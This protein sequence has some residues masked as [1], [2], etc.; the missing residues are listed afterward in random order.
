M[1]L[2][3]LQF[4]WYKKKKNPS[5][6]SYIGF[7]SFRSLEQRTRTKNPPPWSAHYTAMWEEL[8][9]PSEKPSQDTEIDLK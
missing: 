7:R 9:W 1:Q 4:Y 2:S 5:H 6:C 8:E 3:R